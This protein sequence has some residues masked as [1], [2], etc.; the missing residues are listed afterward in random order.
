MCLNEILKKTHKTLKT[1]LLRLI[2]KKKNKIF[3]IHI[4]QEHYISFK[5]KKLLSLSAFQ[6]LPSAKSW[7]LEVGRKREKEEQ[8]SITGLV[9]IIILA[10]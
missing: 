7:N 5:G 9:P 1:L 4:V 10:A 3:A 6:S 2:L 8:N